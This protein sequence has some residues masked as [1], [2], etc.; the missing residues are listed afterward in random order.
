MSDEGPDEGRLVVGSGAAP[1]TAMRV[2]FGAEGLARHGLRP[3]DPEAVV[4][5][6]VYRAEDLAEAYSYLTRRSRAALLRLLVSAWLAALVTLAVLTGDPAMLVLAVFYGLLAVL[7]RGGLR[8]RAYSRWLLSR[9]PALAGEHHW[10]VSEDGIYVRRPHA[11]SRLGW[12]AVLKVAESP[13][14]FLVFPQHNHCHV[15][16]KRD[17]APEDLA[18]LRD[19][20]RRR[21][22]FE[23]A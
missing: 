12:P 9:E 10:E 21:T 19:L 22:R 1:S 15:I 3:A 2:S 8:R 11:E 18:R 5:A 7:W 23:A 16:P 14:A 13:G 17:L 6:C 20:F 4:I